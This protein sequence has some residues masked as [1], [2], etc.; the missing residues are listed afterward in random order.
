MH[1]AGNIPRKIVATTL[2]LAVIATAII[3]WA[4]KKREPSD[5]PES[6]R[7]IQTHAPGNT[8]AAPT[9]QGQRPVSSK[10]IEQAQTAKEKRE[11]SD[12]PKSTRVIQT[13]APGNTKAA[14]TPQEQKPVSPDWTAKIRAARRLRTRASVLLRR[15]KDDE[16]YSLLQRAAKS[17]ED[18]LGEAPN[19]DAPPTIHYEMYR[20]YDA[21]MDTMLRE[22]AFRRYIEGLTERDGNEAACSA[23]LQEAQRLSSAGEHRRA[24]QCVEI[25]L[26]RKPT[27]PTA[28][29]SFELLANFALRRRDVDS[30]LLHYRAVLDIDPPAAVASATQRRMVR[31]E[32]NAGWVNLALRDAENFWATAKEGVSDRYRVEELRLW[33]RAHEQA[34]D[35]ASATKILLR[36]TKDFDRRITARARRDM[37]RIIDAIVGDPF[38]Q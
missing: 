14:A 4:P 19:G 8:K 15:Q 3:L 26:A 36:I 23:L 37:N 13:D 7:V 38:D 6:T 2:L 11:P 32:L 34:G 9:P 5:P 17:L 24:D 30:A 31:M 12:P 28:I 35:T 33:A 25:V 18:M 10:Q 29:R 27:Q 20:C 21:L 1:H 16:A 22:N